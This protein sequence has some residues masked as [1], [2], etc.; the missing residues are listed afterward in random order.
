MVTLSSDDNEPWPEEIEALRKIKSGE[1][2]MDTVTL[3]ELLKEL[4]YE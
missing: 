2:K 4:D 3:E 1:T